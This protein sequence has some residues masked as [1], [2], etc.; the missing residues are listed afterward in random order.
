MAVFAK[1][2]LW[3]DA[4]RQL[5]KDR[6]AKI[7][8]VIIVFY[9]LIALLAKLGVIASDFAVAEMGEVYEKPSLRFWF[10][11]DLF[12][13]DV[14]QRA[15]QGTRI[16]FAIGFI[17]SMIAIPIGVFLGALAGYFGSWIDDFVV[18][19]YTT[20]DSIPAILLIV[21]LSYVLG[22]GITNA[23]IAIGL[24]SWVRLCR[25]VRG[26]FLKHKNRE[27]AIAARAIG[28][29]HL[30][31]IFKHILPNVYPLILI[32][33]S[34]SFVFAIKSEVILSF[35]GLGVEV[36]TPS[37]GVMIDDAKQELSRGVWWPLA[38]ATIFMFGLVL[39]LNLFNDS[40]REALDPKSK[41]RI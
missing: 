2:S 14:L 28:V 32:N 40:L 6:V 1:N 29:S 26:E 33:F 19:F 15:I 7:C 3:A 9:G 16:A 23:F 41:N 30:G 18:W 5:K 27:Y 21:S 25:L 20:V 11:T 38:A 10:G 12:G 17:S 13:R 4:I 31:R 34:L 24:T 39:S 35:L 22:Q 8:F 36:G 37:W